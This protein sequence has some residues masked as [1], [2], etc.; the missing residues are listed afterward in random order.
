MK[1][2]YL[3]RNIEE[4]GK[5]IAFCIEKDISVFRTYWDE[6]KKGN[7]CYCID[8]DEKR[9]LYSSCEYF[10]DRGYEILT[11]VFYFDQFG[12]CQIGKS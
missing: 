10:H 2:A 5:L 6:R 11:P 3:I 12:V 8:W 9:C 1:K 4:Y 7:R